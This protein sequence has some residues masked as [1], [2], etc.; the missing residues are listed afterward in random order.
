M[1]VYVQVIDTFTGIYQTGMIDEKVQ[2]GHEVE[3]ALGH[4]GVRYGDVE[5]ETKQQNYGF[6]KVRD[7]FKVI[8]YYE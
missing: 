5:W 2:E 3:N 7:S 4:F 8:M 1:R 6:G